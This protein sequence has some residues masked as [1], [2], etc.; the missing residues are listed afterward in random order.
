MTGAKYEVAAQIKKINEIC[1]LT[2]CYYHSLSLAVWDKEKSIDK[3]E[4]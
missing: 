2:H 3:E 4:S 1:L